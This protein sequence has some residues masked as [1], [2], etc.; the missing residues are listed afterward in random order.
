VIEAS[1]AAPTT[2]Q[3]RKIRGF[4]AATAGVTFVQ[5]SRLILVRR[6]A[7]PQ[8]DKGQKAKDKGTTRPPKLRDRSDEVR[9]RI[10][11]RLIA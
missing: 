2:V 5:A 11:L 10:W 4:F 6:V 3:P 7:M 9:L 1:S 8:K